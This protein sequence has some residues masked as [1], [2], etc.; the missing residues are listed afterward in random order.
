MTVGKHISRAPKWDQPRFSIFFGLEVTA[1]LRYTTLWWLFVLEHS[2]LFTLVGF[3]F[4]R[5]NSSNKNQMTLG[6]KFSGATKW[7]QPRFSIFFC[8]E[9]TAFPRYKTVR[10]LL[11]LTNSYHHTLVSYNS[12]KNVQGCAHEVLR[13]NSANNQMGWIGTDGANW[14]WWGDSGHPGQ[15][16]IEE[17]FVFLSNGAKYPYSP[18]LS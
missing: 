7:D 16:G 2:N 17:A 1:F 14:D 10:W 9:V 13:Q 18:H 12:T 4:V 11:D 15:T 6:K 3:S 8:L 5:K